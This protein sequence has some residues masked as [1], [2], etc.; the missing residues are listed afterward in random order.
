MAAVSSFLAAAAIA[1][2]LYS[3]ERQRSAQK[4]AQNAQRQ[5]EMEARRI[6]SEKKP[7]EESATLKTNTGIS[8]GTLDY[9]GLTIEPTEKKKTSSL[10]VSQTSS[11]LGFGV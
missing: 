7:M 2:G 11:G 10:G 8:S 4:D 3:A 1:G 5:A 9:L 6:A